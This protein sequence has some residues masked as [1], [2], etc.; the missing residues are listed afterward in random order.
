M[1]QW[2]GFSLHAGVAA[3]ALER[4]KLERLC[5]YISRPAVATER[6]SQTA[7]GR[8]RYTL[9]T[10]YRD[11]TTHVLFEP[12][13]FLSRLAA[14]VPSPGVNL[15]RY[16]GV[17][18][19]NHRLRAQIVPARRGR[20][21]GGG[22]ADAPGGVPKH[23]PLGWAARLKRVFGI[24]IQRCEQCGGAAKIIASIEDPQL[25]ERILAHVDSDRLGQIPR[26]AAARGPPSATINLFESS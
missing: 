26:A 12:L 11:G 15:T 4:D 16:H 13:D 7:D 2:S 21:S 25:I 1:A 10:P 19:P 23:V 6:L 8:I 9:K 5:R 24:D 3:D 20:G 22:R 17:F 14:L 18:A